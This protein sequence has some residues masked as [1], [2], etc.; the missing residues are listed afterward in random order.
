MKLISY[1]VDG[2][3]SFGLWTAAGPAARIWGFMIRTMGHCDNRIRI[4]VTNRAPAGECY[5]VSRC[6]L[7]AVY[8]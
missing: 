1:R 7:K 4:Y 2:H 6:L 5:A 3:A 8:V